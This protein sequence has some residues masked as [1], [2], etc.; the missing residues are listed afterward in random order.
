MIRFL[1]YAI[2]VA[3]HIFVLFEIAQAK[4]VALM[5][6]WAWF[7][8]QVVPVIGPILWLVAGKNPR[9]FKRDSGPDDDLD[10]LIGL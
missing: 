9:K 7:L 8:I 4:I 1:L 3:L 10:F 6:K 2:P 5:P